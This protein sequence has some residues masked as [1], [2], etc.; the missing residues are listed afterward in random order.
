M[1]L[2]AQLLRPEV[3]PLLDLE[4][5]QCVDALLAGPFP[6]LGGTHLAR[7]FQ[8]GREEIRLAGDVG[9]QLTHVPS[10]AVG[11]PGPVLGLEC[12]DGVGDALVRGLG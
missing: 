10:G 8:G 4:R 2:G 7:Q 1:Q 6:G 12:V 11:G 5:G 3:L 9:N